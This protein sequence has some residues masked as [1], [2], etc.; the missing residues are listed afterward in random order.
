MCIF[1]SHPAKSLLYFLTN[2]SH[3]FGLESTANKG[4]RRVGCS[5]LMDVGRASYLFQGGNKSHF[6]DKLTCADTSGL[7]L[8]SRT[9]FP[10]LSLSAQMQKMCGVSSL[11]DAFYAFYLIF[12]LRWL[13]LKE[14]G[15][16][17]SVPPPTPT[18]TLFMSLVFIYES[19]S[20]RPKLWV[21]QVSPESLSVH[22]LTFFRLPPGPPSPVWFCLHTCLGLA[23]NKY[24]NNLFMCWLNNFCMCR[25]RK[26][27]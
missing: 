6:Y 12:T 25:K 26:W 11:F 9:Y 14:M 15:R 27:S 19:V 18:L 7:K 23:V 17:G 5:V 10:Q 22:A 3:F 24:F 16:P 4:K 8:K 20:L 2:G 21:F 1:F 13:S